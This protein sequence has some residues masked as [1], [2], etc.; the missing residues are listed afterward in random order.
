MRQ[1]LPSLVATGFL[2]TGALLC[3]ACVLRAA[4]RGDEP[5]PAREAKTVEIPVVTPSDLP[6]PPAVGNAVR[7]GGEAEGDLV[8]GGT[9]FYRAGRCRIDTPLPEG[10][11]P[12]TA[13][14]AIEIKHYPGAR[15]AE[16]SGDH[17]P[18]LASNFA[19]F[20]LFE[21]I[22]E[23]EIAMTSPVE[24]DYEPS[25]GES[26]EGEPE[27]GWTMSFL[28]RTPTMGETG[29]AGYV[30][31]VDRP[32]VVVLSIGVRGGYG[33]RQVLPRIDDLHAWVEKLDGWEAAGP[34]RGLYYNGPNVPSRDRWVE[35]QLPIR[36]VV[37]AKD[38]A[39]RETKDAAPA[40]AASGREVFLSKDDG[41][42]ARPR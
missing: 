25:E 34:P 38:D 17:S 22:Q 40:P 15:R 42:E 7:I 8:A 11:P 9:H 31:V 41:G 14:G 1:H 21:H 6:T 10:Y 33:S 35:A 36:R 18:D 27:T 29:E 26:S 30:T 32:A 39:E 12:P 13:P 3:S 5:T 20:R 2:L 24:M 16:V 37:E 4:P 19:F 28:Y 23:R